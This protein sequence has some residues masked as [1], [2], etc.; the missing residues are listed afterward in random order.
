MITGLAY[1][2]MRVRGF[3]ESVGVYG[4]KL[5]LTELQN[6]TAVLS[7]R[8]EWLSTS[9][10]EAGDRE[11]V[12]QV[13]DSLLILHED[14][15]AITHW[16]S[17]RELL[18]GDQVPGTV[19]HLSYYADDNYHTYFHWRSFL[20]E[21]RGGVGSTVDGPS[22]QPM[23]HSYLQRSLLE[24]TDPAGLTVQVSEIIDPRPSKRAR[25]KGKIEIANGCQGGLV[26]GFDHL[27][28]HCSDIA[29]AREF[30]AEKLGLG[31]IDESESDAHIGCV[32]TA[33]LTDLELG[34]RKDQANLPDLSAGVVG[35][36]GLWCDDLGEVISRTGHTGAPAERDLALGLSV[37]SI[38]MD[39]GDGFMVE[40]AQRV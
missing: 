7:D 14:P 17:D 2:E 25:R 39:S 22:V 16:L 35:S 19:T 9:S 28:M 30:Y 15:Q 21:N 23:N 36:L 18:P 10:V 6:T 13:G 34:A 38:R 24:F 4:Q 31:I 33:G 11:A 27:N 29:V 8:G 12:F 1:V 20:H 40:I 37:R 26:R 5:G 32:F 3:D